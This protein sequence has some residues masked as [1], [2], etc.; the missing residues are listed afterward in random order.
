MDWH[1][2]ECEQKKNFIQRDPFNVFHICQEEKM[3]F[4][5]KFVIKFD[6]IKLTRKF[7]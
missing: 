4:E 5:E 1:P 3:H 2:V 7:F 6:D